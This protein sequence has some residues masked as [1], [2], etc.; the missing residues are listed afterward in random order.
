MLFRSALINT[1]QMWC[2]FMG[3]V[4]RY[5][6]H[7][8]TVNIEPGLYDHLRMNSHQSSL[9][10]M[11]TGKDFNGSPIKVS[12]ATRRADFGR[13]GGGMRGGRGRGGEHSFRGPSFILHSVYFIIHVNPD[14]KRRAPVSVFRPDGKRRVWRRKR[15]RKWWRFP[16]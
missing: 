1:P 11:L 6:V 9:M 15:R 13:G 5:V 12:F 4:G 8:D 3:K 2:L 7:P 14:T 10:W 16:W